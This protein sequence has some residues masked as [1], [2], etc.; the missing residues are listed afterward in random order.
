MQSAD[1][2]SWLGF[3]LG[4]LDNDC[5]VSFIITS[6][7]HW[8]IA[9]LSTRCSTSTAIKSKNNCNDR[10]Y[11]NASSNCTEK[12]FDVIS[13][14]WKFAALSLKKWSHYFIS[15]VCYRL[16]TFHK[17]TKINEQLLTKQYCVYAPAYF[18]WNV[19]ISPISDGKCMLFD[20]WATIDTS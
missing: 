15:A 18:Q 14:V 11:R 16:I 8:L 3:R 9:L 12:S 7:M 5:R 4:T 10:N 17:P 1:R 20:S 6:E 13:K 19:Y 2:N